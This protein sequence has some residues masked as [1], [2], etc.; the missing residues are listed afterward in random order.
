MGITKITRRLAFDEVTETLNKRKQDILAELALCEHGA[1]A[2]ELAYFMWQKK[3]FV[4]PERNRVHPRL[5]EL[6]KD[7]LVKVSEKRLCNLTKRLCAVYVIKE[8]DL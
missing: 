6:V 8:N 4:T 7:G 1:T 3:Y 2:N 5:N